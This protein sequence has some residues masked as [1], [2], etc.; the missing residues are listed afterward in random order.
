M[1][2][3]QGLVQQ[4]AFEHSIAPTPSRYIGGMS[5][6]S[7]GVPKMHPLKSSFPVFRASS[8]LH[9]LRLKTPKVPGLRMP[10]V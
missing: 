1:A 3:L 10:R 5:G 7:E 9:G 2:R 4:R 8:M 6:A